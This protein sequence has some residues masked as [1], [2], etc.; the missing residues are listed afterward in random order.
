MRR[1]AGGDLYSRMPRITLLRSCL[2][3]LLMTVPARWPAAGREDAADDDRRHAHAGAG[4]GDARAEAARGERA[5]VP[6]VLREAYYD[7]RGY[8]QCFLRWGANDGP[9]DA[10]ENFNRWPELH[11][12]GADDEIRQMYLKAWEGMTRQYSEA[13][14]KETPA[15]RDGHVCQGLLRRSPTGCTTAKALQLFNRISL[16]APDLPAL[17]RAG[18]ALRRVLHG[19]R[20]GGAEL[21][22]REEADSLDDQRQPRS[23]AAQGDGARLGRRSVRCDRVRRAPRRE[24]ATRSSSST[25]ANT[26]TSSATTSSTWRRR[27]CRPTRICSTGEAAYRTLARRLHGCVAGA[28]EAERRHHSEL[29]RSRRHDRRQGSDGGGERLRVGLQPDQS[30]EGPA[31][32]SQPHPVGARRIQQRAARHGRSEVCRRLARDDRH[33]ELARA[34]RRRQEGV[35]DDVRRRWLV[36][37]A[38][39]AVERRS[40]GSVVSGRCVRR[41]ASG[42]PRIRRSSS[43]TA[44]T[45]AIP[46]PS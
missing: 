10:F 16:S 38:G 13:K 42:W 11:A 21:R 39:R 29:R 20:S 35:S 32:E 26:P 40:A 45:P 27:R 8:I 28:H 17:A 14:T 34:R 12:L 2:A 36:W 41:I 6:R 46:R 22:P 30:G 19:H 7:E 24:Y 18:E 15:G 25:T 31:R 5:R 1:W 37:M 4:L 43:S 23:A 9:D 33:G 3:A 44:R